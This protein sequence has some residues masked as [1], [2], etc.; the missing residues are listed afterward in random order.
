MANQNQGM[1]I[2]VIVFV[3]LWVISTALMVVFVNK[4]THLEKLLTTAEKSAADNE[5]AFLGVQEELNDVKKMVVPASGD[6]TIDHKALRDRFMADLKKHG[7]RLKVID[8]GKEVPQSYSQMLD[9]ALAALDQRN[10]GLE[11]E[12]IRVADLEKQNTA[13]AATYQAQVDQYKKQAEAAETEKTSLQSKLTTAEQNLKNEQVQ[14][15]AQLEDLRTK[16]E[17]RAAELTKELNDTK[18]K[19]TT[20]ERA[21]EALSRR[22]FE[23]EE[24]ANTASYDGEV[25]KVNPSARTVW[26]N[27]GVYDNLPKHLTFSVQ[28]RGVPAGSEVPPK[29]KI[30][31]VQILADHLA[32]CRILEDDLRNPILAGDN[33]FTQLWEPGQRTRFAFAGKIDLDNNGTDDMDQVRALVARAGGQIDAEVVNGELKGK[34]DIETRYLVLGTVPA[35]KNS[36][37]RYNELTRE[38]ERLGIQRVPMAVFFDQIGYK[39][40]GRT[41]QFGGGSAGA[42]ALEAPDGGMPVSQGTVSDVFKPRRPV[43]P[44]ARAR[45]KSPDDV[46]GFGS[47]RLGGGRFAEQCT[48]RFPSASI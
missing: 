38:A 25:T 18:D 33:I 13:L 10:T 22:L 36:A 20:T 4:G 45:T 30:E 21:N 3:I 34:L 15:T 7:D 47:G 8:A 41:M 12:K 39:R 35:D 48:R 2:A 14:V 17:A 16:G 31:V 46:F 40:Q 32:E 37:D 29:G 28:G 1:T 9:A 44:R 26:V 5:A 19:L 11:A 24:R 42:R 6:S 23:R 27:L 43:P